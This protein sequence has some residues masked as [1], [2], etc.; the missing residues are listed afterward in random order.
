M[1]HQRFRQNRKIFQFIKKDFKFMKKKV[2]V[3][4][5]IVLLSVFLFLLTPPAIYLRSLLVMSV[6]SGHM[7]K[8]SLMEEKG[9]DIHI[10]GGLATWKTDWYPFVMTFVDNKG[11]QSYMGNKNLSL[12]ILYNFPAFSL[13]NGCSRLFDEKSPYFNGFYGAYLVS[14]SS[15]KSYGFDSDG[16]I[17]KREV[18]S[19]PEF[20]F[21][22]LVL[23]DFGLSQEDFIFDCEITKIKEDISYSGFDGWTRIDSDIM[24]NHACHT[25]RQNVM[26]YL[27]YGSPNY[28]PSSEFAVIPMKGRIYAR[29]FS[30]WN[31]SIFYYII[32]VDE[33]ILEECD[34]KILSRSKLEQVLPDG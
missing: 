6:Y 3:K 5:I 19:V 32:T 7:K 11:F 15:G 30:E 18:I 12:T 29:Y 16:N 28:K 17:N 22:W 9:F 25:A 26:S 34:E 1:N 10:P 21:Y 8:E 31:V 14:D 4:C 23:Q 33:E 13:L 2:P 20:D 24:V 27:Q